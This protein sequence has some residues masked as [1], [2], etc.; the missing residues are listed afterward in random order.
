[1]GDRD[2]VIIMS[3]DDSFLFPAT[4]DD[5]YI[6]PGATDVDVSAIAARG[7][8]AYVLL[9]RGIDNLIKLDLSLR[10]PQAVAIGTV[11]VD[12]FGRD[13]TVG[14][15]RVVVASFDKV[16]AVDRVSLDAAGNLAVRDVR[17]VRIVQRAELGLAGDVR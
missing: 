12:S 14:C 1:L 5:D 7:G 3:A 9:T 13:M 10:P 15:R 8:F 6:I 2:R 17:K 11:D 16:V 4:D